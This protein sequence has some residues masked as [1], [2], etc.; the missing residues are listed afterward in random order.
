MELGAD[1]DTP[2]KNNAAAAVT[3]P[4]YSLSN[5][6]VAPYTLKAPLVAANISPIKASLK[7][8]AE[9]KQQEAQILENWVPSACAPIPNPVP[10]LNILAGIDVVLVFVRHTPV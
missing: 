4:C 6:A 3:P 5:P 10:L 8:I 7:S 9:T 2:A 1:P